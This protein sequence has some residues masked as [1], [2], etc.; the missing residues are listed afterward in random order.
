MLGLYL[1]WVEF[2]LKKTEVLS[3]RT[4]FFRRN[5]GS[6]FVGEFH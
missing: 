1:I 3:V 6:V 2:F 4:D 5:H